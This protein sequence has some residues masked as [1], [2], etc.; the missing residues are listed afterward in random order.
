[1]NSPELNVLVIEDDEF[2]RHIM[3]RILESIGIAS[4][5][6]AGNGKEALEIIRGVN[7]KPI[8]VAICDLNMP[9]MD[10]MEFLR[11]LGQGGHNISVIL[12]SALDAKLLSSVG[13]MTKLY[14]IKLLGIME[15]PI[16]LSDLEA[17]LAKHDNSSFLHEGPKQNT[18]SLKEIMEG[19]ESDQ[20]EPY[21]QAKVDLGSGR[22]VGAEALARWL[23]PEHG[24]VSP[25][26]FIPALEEARDIDRLTFRIIEKTAA[27]CRDFHEQGH[28]LAISVNLSLTSLDDTSLA[29]RITELVRKSG[30]DPQYLILEIT[31]SAAMTNVA[32]ALENLA[33][34]CM[35]GFSLSIDDYGTGASNLQQLTRIAFSE[36]K[37]DQSFVKD[38]TE[39]KALMVVVKSSIDMARKLNV[40]SVAEG[41]ETKQDCEALKNAG[42]DTAQGFYIS[43]PMDR[44]AFLKFMANY[45]PE[46]LIPDV[47]DAELPPQRKVNILVVDDDNFARK[48]ILQVLRDLGYTEIIDAADAE[49]AIKLFDSKSFD[50]VIT[51]VNMPGMNGLKF[52]QMIRS[53]KTRAK[54]GTRI[55]VLTLFSQT[56]VLSTALALDVNG[57]LV[58]PIIPSVA[59]E[60]LACAMNEQLHLRSPIAYESVRTEAKSLPRES[61]K[62]LSGAA[63]VLEDKKTQSQNWKGRTISLNKVRPGMILAQSVYLNDGML[64]LSAGHSLSEV[65]INRLI[66]LEEILAAEGIVIQEQIPPNV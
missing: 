27:A 33:R 31:E 17:L 9:E 11:H 6:H 61:T 1:M 46:L 10:G 20:F 53:G 40:K 59:E 62:T 18:Y 44:H 54:P 23:H 4:V 47:A 21:F 32:P 39:N 34:L 49:S 3:S 25:G 45:R 65:S 51:D 24:V 35:N 2:Q 12:T 37:I 30:L 42:C 50:L 7:S 29:D 15:K 66:D 43:K 64:I 63:V 52:I 16:Q 19:V 5:L 22:L 13:R 38:F 26:A 55:M 41:V 8:E 14:G 56:E 48:I 57:F 58:K 28:I 60:K 36:L